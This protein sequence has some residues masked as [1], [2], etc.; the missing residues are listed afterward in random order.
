M[1]FANVVLLFGF[2]LLLAPSLYGVAIQILFAQLYG[3]KQS[4]VQSWRALKGQHG[5]IIRLY[6]R[7]SL[8][9]LALTMLVLFGI[10]A[11]M[12]ILSIFI[13]LFKEI[14][15][16][17]LSL[18]VAVACIGVTSGVCSILQLGAIIPPSVEGCRGA[19]AVER[20]RRLYLHSLSTLWT[21]GLKVSIVT[22]LIPLLSSKIL[23]GFFIANASS[24]SSDNFTWLLNL[25]DIVSLIYAPVSL[26][27][28]W[29]IVAK[30][31]V[32]MARKLA[33]LSSAED[34]PAEE[35]AESPTE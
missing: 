3:R 25:Q 24:V 18:Y 17:Q 23:I 6:L 14:G 15:I 34:P 21:T 16:L 26:P 29:C 32:Q 22:F 27:L 35:D 2:S 20:R 19:E 28:V 12:L 30:A 4:I 5:S 11:C 10:L 31:H 1:P 33:G 7:G 13:P 8:L 9:G